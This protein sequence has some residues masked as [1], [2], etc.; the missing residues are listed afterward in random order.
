MTLGDTTNG[1]MMLKMYGAAQADLRRKI[2]YNL[3]RRLG[4]AAGAA[5]PRDFTRSPPEMGPWAQA[6]FAPRSSVA[7][8]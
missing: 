4:V 2:N 1:L 3:H 5:T 6:S 7:R 8:V